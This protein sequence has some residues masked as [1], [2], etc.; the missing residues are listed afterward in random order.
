MLVDDD[1]DIRSS[2][3]AVLH[4]AGYTVIEARDGGQVVDIVRREK[5]ALILLDVDMPRV[6]GWD[7]LRNLHEERCEHPVVMLTGCVEIDDRVKGLSLGADDYLCKPCN[8]RELLARVHAVLR[9]SRPE[10]RG[11]NVLAFGDLAVNLT[12]RSAR[13]GTEPVKF[14][15]TEYAMLELLSSQMGRLVTREQMLE[16]VWG[17]GAA[18]NTRTVD[19]HIWRLRQKLQDDAHA[20]R[21]IQSVPAGGGYR[22]V[23]EL[24]TA[25]RSV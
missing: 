15:R 5:P 23:A 9:R 24:V 18:S 20:P 10:P 1:D 7:A 17:Y 2:Y 16:Q 11:H 25:D 6:N 12:E 14:T 22:L 8:H 3:S 21:W 4:G 13:R 19:T